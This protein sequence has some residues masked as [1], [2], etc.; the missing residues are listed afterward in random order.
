MENR[1]EVILEKRGYKVSEEGIAYNKRG[2]VVGFMHSEY[3]T[4]AI[5][6]NGK[7]KRGRVH[8]L[9]AYQKYGDKLFEEGV[10]VRH[11]DGVN[12]NNA[13]D[14]IL[15]GSHSDNMMDI[16]EN[17][18]LKKALHATSSTRKYDKEKVIAFHAIE[19]SYK[20]TME[21]FGIGSKGTLYHIL[22]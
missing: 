20:K 10:L 11:Y 12:L 5:K 17:I 4:L 9:Q 19:K 13:W 6:I 14:N 16:P 15:I 2:D 8:R 21:E 7:T 22:K 18:R 3:M 1:I